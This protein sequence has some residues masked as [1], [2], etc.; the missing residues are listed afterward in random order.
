MPRVLYNEGR[1]VG[2]SAY[3]IYVRHA[4]ASDP[5]APPASESEWLSST[6]GLGSSMLLY[7]APEEASVNGA[8]YVEFMLPIT[9]R[10]CGAST[11]LGSF[12]IGSGDGTVWSEK[13]ASYGQLISNTSSLSPTSSSIPTATIT[14]ID[15]A[16]SDALRDFCKIIDGV[17]VQDGTW[18]SNSTSPPEKHLTPDFTKKPKVRIQL[19]DRV[20]NGFYVLLSGFTDSG[21]IYGVSTTTGSETTAAPQNGDFL[22]PAVFPW[23]TKIMFS[24]PTSAMSLIGSSY[25]T[26]QFQYDSNEI[27]V[28]YS[29]IIDFESADIPMYYSVYDP[30]SAV[31]CTVSSVFTAQSGATVLASR[32]VAGTVDD[33]PDIKLPPDLIG[34]KILSDGEYI[35]GPLASYSPYSIHLFHGDIDD[36][37]VSSPTLKAKLLESKFPSAYSFIRSDESYVVYELKKLQT[38]EVS[39]IPVSDSTLEN[40]NAL[41]IYNSTYLYFHRMHQGGGTPTSDDLKNVSSFTTQQHIYGCVSQK[42]IDDYCMTYAETVAR[43]GTG[44]SATWMMDLLFLS[45]YNQTAQYGDKYVYFLMGQNISFSGPSQQMLLI[46][47][48][49]N[50]GRISTMFAASNRVLIDGT[51]E[52]NIDCSDKL[53]YLGSFWNGTLNQSDPSLASWGPLTDHPVVKAVIGNADAYYQPNALT[54]NP[55]EIYSKNYLQWYKDTPIYGNLIDAETWATKGI[56]ESYKGLSVLDFLMNSVL[57]YVGMPMG[58]A[59]A[60]RGDASASLN[61]Q[62]YVFK[63]SSIDAT[64]AGGYTVDQDSHIVFTVD[65][66]SD[67][68]F[69]A[70]LSRQIFYA[71]S[72]IRMS[73]VIWSGDSGRISD[74]DITGDFISSSN[75]RLFSVGQ[76]G[77]H[78]TKSLSMVDEYGSPLP[79]VG[80]AGKIQSDLIRWTDLVEALDHNKSVD[81]LGILSKLKSALSDPGISTGVSYMIQLNVDGTISLVQSQ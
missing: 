4:L 65:L 27:T 64:I 73:R 77:T 51:T 43:F 54:P 70:N 32:P 38:N 79:L 68:S 39:L 10:L 1:V 37:T 59:E 67:L 12:F 66:K 17:V 42:F 78:T 57:N 11:I 58:S 18:G 36:M 52:L 48:E 35:F 50:T 13:V 45:M 49:K 74:N 44:G 46:P 8:H 71:P 69:K 53:D 16:T 6:L 30:D 62:R 80:G 72:N 24:I 22:G 55:P 14:D 5:D 29:A 61:F 26:R 34:G 60:A 75:T 28:D 15:Q 41:Q 3:E 25:Y 63:K 9:S 76:S 19:R 31:D 7:V 33:V 81:I 47:V 20:I 56:D 2:Y 21:V 40:A 23:A